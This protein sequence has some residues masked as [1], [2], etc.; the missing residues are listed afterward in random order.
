MPHS[1]MRIG[2]NLTYLDSMR[3][4]VID[5]NH[6][7]IGKFDYFIRGMDIIGDCFCDRGI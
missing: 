6:N 5:M 3:G 4:Q 1:L 2:P 7:I